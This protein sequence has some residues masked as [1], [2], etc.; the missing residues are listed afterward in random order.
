MKIFVAGASG[1]VAEEL[2]KQLSQAGYQVL[3]GARNTDRVWNGPGIEAVKLDLH[4]SVDQLAD[5]IKDCQA[6]YFV[7][8][9]RG[10]DLLQ[11][12]VYGAIKLMEASQKVGLNRFMMLSSLF[13][14][15]P[16]KWQLPGLNQMM[17]Y[18]IS[19]FL[20]DHYL[21]HQTKLDYTIL[22]PGALVESEAKGKVAFYPETLG[23]NSIKDVAR[24]LALLL[25]HPQASKKVITMIEGEQPIEEALQEL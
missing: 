7:A 17:D 1:R 24:V 8:G 4:D 11:T 16:T 2:L 3:A 23:S 15:E 18:N 13:A 20:A 25:E 21:I 19:K 6:L 5:I 12:D 22:Q 9:S 10:K 14:L